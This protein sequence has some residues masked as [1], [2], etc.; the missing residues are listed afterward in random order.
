M[1]EKKI[2]RTEKAPLPIGPY[3]QAV[4]AGNFLFVSGQIPLKP[5]N[6]ELVTSGIEDETKQVMENI[7]AILKAA[8]ADFSA[9]VKTTIFLADMNDFTT[10]NKVYGNYFDEATAPARETIQVAKLPKN[11]RVEISVVAVL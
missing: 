9:V 3:N 4:R 2:I 1:S 8:G 11:A 7:H 5:E 6:G 10:V